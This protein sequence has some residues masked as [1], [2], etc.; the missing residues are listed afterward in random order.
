MRAFSASSGSSRRSEP[1]RWTWRSVFGSFSIVSSGGSVGV[2][3]DPTTSPTRSRGLHAYV[4]RHLHWSLATHCPSSPWCTRTASRSTSLPPASQQHWRF[5][6]FIGGTR[7]HGAGAVALR[8]TRSV[9]IADLAAA[10]LRHWPRVGGGRAASPAATAPV[11]RRAAVRTGVGLHDLLGGG[12]EV[13]AVPVLHRRWWRPYL[14]R[15]VSVHSAIRAAAFLPGEQRS[16]G[17][18][19]ERGS[20]SVSWRRILARSPKTGEKSARVAARRV[21]SKNGANGEKFPGLYLRSSLTGSGS[22]GHC[23]PMS[24]VSPP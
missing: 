19:A 18:A 6:L 23:P 9:R 2:M 11:A 22:V 3:T 5:S 16:A 13:R 12:R 14:R 4:R 20:R 1:S 10:G 17:V 7:L 21:V 24:P 15:N 8:D